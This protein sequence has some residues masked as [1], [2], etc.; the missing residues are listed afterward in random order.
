MK[1][2]LAWGGFSL[3]AAMA[4]AGALPFGAAVWAGVLCAAAAAGGLFVFL[5]QKTQAVRAALFV[6]VFLTVGFFWRAG[7][8]ALRVAPALPYDGQ[9]LPVSAT[10]TTYP[11]RTAYGVAVRADV[12]L[13]Q[14]VTARA[15]LYLDETLASL[16][17]GDVMACTA[18]LQAPLPG[19]PDDALSTY[20]RY[21]VT[22]RAVARG[23]VTVSSPEHIS[24]GARFA[25]LSHGFKEGFGE[26]FAPE[27]AGFLA[28][29]LTGDTAG[30]PPG[31]AA[32]LSDTG[33]AHVVSVSGLHVSFLAGIVFTLCRKRRKLAFFVSVPILF[34]FI[35][36]IGFPPSA[37]RAGVMQTA[38]L[39]ALLLG[40]EYDGL[41]ALSL[42]L[43]LLVLL[44]PYAIGD[45]GL[46]L[47][48]A[49]TLGILLFARSWQKKLTRP[50][51]RYL[52]SRL[53][54]FVGATLGTSLAA[55]VFSLP[56]LAV[57]FQSISLVSPIAN[58][59]SL[60]LVSFSFLGGLI[61]RLLLLL[62]APLA[63]VVAFPVSLALELFAGIIRT[64]AGIPFAALKLQNEYFSAFFLLAYSLF[65]LYFFRRKTLQRRDFIFPTALTAAGLALAL[66]FTFARVA[67][68]EIIA[69]DVGQGQCLLVLTP[70]KT[71]VIDCGGGS[72]SVARTAADALKSLG[73]FKIDLLI[74]THTHE[75]HAGGA[76]VLLDILPVS[77]I[78]LPEGEEPNALRN[79]ILLDAAERNIPVTAVDTEL[80]LPLGETSLTV[81]PPQGLG[82]QNELCLSVLCQKDGFE[83]LATGDLPAAM[84]RALLRQ[85]TL[86]DIEV[87]IV[88][89]HGSRTSTSAELLDASLPE[90]GVISVG[91]RNTYGHPGGE[92]LA[93][94]AERD[95][96]IFRTDLDGNIH[97]RVG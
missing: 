73:R 17:P 78:L 51:K 53:F 65:L 23:A 35:A 25:I 77:Q 55:L 8:D 38:L 67:P 97:I 68:L 63:L 89:H 74:L 33:L 49:S 76:P 95:I 71:A 34:L 9:T 69:L 3:A 66:L 16:R 36:M 10:V 32:A 15:I 80:S 50:S 48:F 22:L 5:R 88:G 96:D 86:P 2:P 60:W 87:L 40:Q 64:L 45:I 44:N 19:S 93:R 58:V 85:T 43:G 39:L 91:A 61:A 7:Y 11:E 56:L 18:V 62:W 46:Q 79:S 57:Y 52:P 20:R 30:V 13:P 28:A 84:E 90:V 14:G 72:S 12:V 94:L 59:L 92:T 54:R 26:L 83:L 41:S 81:Y 31:F 75:D 27:Q 42:A 37:V 6:L 4:A 70:E 21:G 82:D 1:R 29:L 24:L 47:S